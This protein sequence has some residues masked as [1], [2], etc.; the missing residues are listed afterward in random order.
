MV[1]DYWRI[2]KKETMQF[3]SNVIEGGLKF[4]KDKDPEGLKDM[5]GTFI[6]SILPVNIQ[7]SNLTGR[8]QSLGSGLNPLIKVPGEYMDN[9][10][11][12]YHSDT[13]PQSLQ[14]AR[15]ENQYRPTTPDVYRILGKVTG[16]SPLKLQQMVGSITGGAIN[17]LSP[18]K[19]VEGRSD[20]ENNPLLS[21]FL[22]RFER[23]QRSDTGTF[24]QE[25]AQA[26]QKQSDATVDLRRRAEEKYAELSKLPKDEANAKAAE[27]LKTDKA[28]FDK[29]KSIKKETDAGITYQDRMVR[30][31]GIKSGVRAQFIYDH[32]MKAYQTKE[33]RNAY[34]Q[35]LYD[36]KIVTAE[37]LQQLKELKQ[38]AGQ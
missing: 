2:P 18:P 1:M 25:F 20:V 17:Q 37:V 5:A 21:P 8:I 32:A 19:T 16:Q 26:Q 23:S 7:G 35:D 6:E 33:E 12:F 3:V 13:V 28:L 4:A 14:K 30:E 31:L 11:W 27:I 24:D 15:P 10:N 36:K 22:N 29:I 9:K 34:I 38:K